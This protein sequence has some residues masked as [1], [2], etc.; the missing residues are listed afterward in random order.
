MR[1]SDDVQPTTAWKSGV[2]D[3]IDQWIEKCFSVGAIVKRLDRD[4]NRDYIADLKEFDEIQALLTQIDANASY[5]ETQ[6]DNYRLSF[7]K[8]RYLWATDLQQM[9]DDF[10]ADATSTTEQGQVLPDLDKFD[11]RLKEFKAKGE[12]IDAL[13]T[14]IDIGWLRIS[15][16]PMRQ[17]MMIY[18][19]KWTFQFTSYLS[20]HVLMNLNQL[21]DFM[22]TVKSGLCEEVEIGRASCRERV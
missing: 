1:C 9:I 5:W 19:N 14:P 13:Q 21:N 4:A 8:F 6:C 17:A 11:E 16:Q 15:S 12:E 18:T 22:G 10:I 20:D 3:C 2:R 7:E